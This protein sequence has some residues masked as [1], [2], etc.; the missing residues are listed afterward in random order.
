[1]CKHLAVFE[2]YWEL[3]SALVGAVL[4]YVFIVWLHLFLKIMGH[5]Y[6][7]QFNHDYYELEMNMYVVNI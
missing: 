6:M 3:G 5:E 7:T 4:Q 2:L 1:M